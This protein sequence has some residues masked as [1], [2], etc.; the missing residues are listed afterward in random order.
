MLKAKK[1]IF[2]DKHGVIVRDDAYCEFEDK[3]SMIAKTIAR[4]NLRIN[5][6]DGLDGRLVSMESEGDVIETFIDSYNWLSKKRDNRDKGDVYITTSEGKF[7]VNIKLIG[8][9]KCPIN[10]CGLTFNS[11]KLLYGTTAQSKVLLAEMIKTKKFTDKVQQYGIIAINKETGD[12]RHAT[13]FN[14]KDLKINPTNGFQVAFNDISSTRRA[15]RAGQE[16]LAKKV[17]EFFERQAQPLNVLN[18]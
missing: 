8:N 17:I 2:S 16:F 1:T 9:I 14:I 18:G 3:L 7:P 10:V 13:L 11:S 12:V 6:P 5:S 4:K 15:Q